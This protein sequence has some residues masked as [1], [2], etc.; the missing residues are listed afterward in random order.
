MPEVARQGHVEKKLHERVI[1][2]LAPLARLAQR[3]PL[4]VADMEDVAQLAAHVDV[5]RCTRAEQLQLGRLL[6]RCSTSRSCRVQQ[7]R[8][9]AHLL[10]TFQKEGAGWTMQ[11]VAALT[12]QLKKFNPFDEKMQRLE[13]LLRQPFSREDVAFVHAAQ[14]GE[15][16]PLTQATREVRNGVSDAQHP[17]GHAASSTNAALCLA[18]AFPVAKK[19]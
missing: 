9:Y 7:T 8:L 2:T 3:E 19:R 12:E 5:S 6:L 4:S 13:T 1:D 17:L 10:T 18:Q 14:T 15:A 16:G 11:E